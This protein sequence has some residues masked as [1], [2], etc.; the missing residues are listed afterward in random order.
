VVRVSL[1]FPF[2][3]RRFPAYEYKFSVE[4]FRAPVESIKAGS[5]D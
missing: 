2:A 3:P 4:V 1:C 5:L